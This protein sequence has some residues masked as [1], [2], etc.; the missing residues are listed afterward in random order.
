MPLARGRSH[1]GVEG[2]VLIKAIGC[3]YLSMQYMMD[4]A[5]AAFGVTLFSFAEEFV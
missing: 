1:C 4:G 3:R 2:L 5:V